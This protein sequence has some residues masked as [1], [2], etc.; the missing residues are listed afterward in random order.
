MKKII[1]LAVVTALGLGFG[2]CVPKMV[3]A[4]AEE[5]RIA[6]Q[7]KTNP[8]KSNIY[9]C[10]NEFLGHAINMP[11]TLN[12]KFIGK[13][14][15][16]SYFYLTVKPGKHNIQSLTENVQTLLLDTEKNKNYFVWQEVKMGMWAA[17]SK[18]HRVTADHEFGKKC[19]LDT[20][21]LKAN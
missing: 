20:Q 12:G 16:S 11:V 7:F 21:M 13:T 15:G 4:S 19:I 17:D 6:K 10:R 2:G 5:D 18:L 14:E 8:E 1:S 3:K 9:I